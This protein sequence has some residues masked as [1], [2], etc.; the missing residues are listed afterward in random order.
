MALASR[1][2]IEI[3]TEA[4]EN[5]K[6][7]Y[8]AVSAVMLTSCPSGRLVES[9][10]QGGSLANLSRQ[11]D[12][13]N[14]LYQPG[15]TIHYAIRYISQSQKNNRSL[16]KIDSVIFCRVSATNEDAARL[17]ITDQTEQLLLQ[18]RG[19]LP[20]YLW[21]VVQDVQEFNRVWRPIDWDKAKVVEVRR[22]EELVALDSI[23]P[24][25]GIG[26]S[27]PDEKKSVKTQPKVYFVHQFLPHPGRLERLL[28]LILLNPGVMT[29][30]I[31]LAPAILTAREEQE[32]ID[33][34]ALSEGFTENS[35]PNM[36]R[37]QERRANMI[38]DGL[39]NQL[40]SLQ[41]A[42]FYMTIMLASSETI[43]STLVEA[44]GVAVS[45][46]VGEDKTPF[47][48]ASSLI[49]MGGYDLV[50]PQT[51]E[52]RLTARGNLSK[53]TQIPW[54]KTNAP[55]ELNRIRYMMDGHQAVCAFRFPED[56]REGL[57][58][59]T[60]HTL[61]HRPV[62]PEL[63]NRVAKL[64]VPQTLLLGTN[65]YLGITNEVLMPIADRLRHMYLVGQTG[66]GKSTLMKTML[67]SD[68]QAGRG[69]ALID[70]HGDLFDEIL[71]YIPPERI[72][73]VVIIDPADMEN[74]V[75]MNLLE[76]KGGDERYF[77]VREM[78]AIIRRILE[79]QYGL[80]EAQRIAGP[81]FYRHMQM[82][83]LLA[84]SDPDHTGTLLEFHEIYMT[85][86]YWK[87]WVPL[88]IDDKQLR[89][90][91]EYLAHNNYT[92]QAAGGECSMGE[93]LCS[94]FSDF[95]F[96][97]RLRLIFGQHNSTFDLTE[98]MDEGKILLINLA[99]GLL[100]ESNARFLGLV[101]MAKIQAE[102]MKRAKVPQSKRKPF[103]LYVDEFQSLAT[104]NFTVLLSEAR[105]FKL[106]IV[107]ANQFISQI[108][109]EKIIQA[110]FGNVGSLLSF[111]LGRDDA[112]TVEPQ[113][114]PFFDMT[115][116]INMPNWTVA[117]RTSVDGATLPPFTLQTTL[118]I[119]EPNPAIARQAREFS[120]KK[121][122]RTR[123]QVE[124]MIAESLKTVVSPKDE[125]LTS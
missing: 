43:P 120:R 71:G 88:K 60:T 2:H 27:Q 7:I 86:D 67:I 106:G 78:Q 82:N 36:Q 69:C 32:F 24:M 39:V 84:M 34:I 9:N 1:P 101:L 111:R 33:A 123:A 19:S 10:G 54:G 93:Y 14:S 61:R 68:M 87:R 6:V 63:V 114:L 102:A 79:D 91:L 51:K 100:G 12:L 62:P 3:F 85:K 56:T 22:R 119:G 28:R 90:W 35:M 4:G 49:Q 66:T 55:P 103:F 29:I 80:F 65:N 26:F 89:S 57:P 115:D 92:T 122:T 112:K 17:L 21:Q 45:A 59:I 99:K 73:D 95:I 108:K 124:E 40:L 18:L 23:R 8:H 110:L 13:I 117:A 31:I 97:P 70:P 38:R 94:K 83:M 107:L 58:G 75:G 25:R 74:P 44:A 125:G 109:D 52:E 53:L 50:T 116:L 46:S 105:K 96:D 37:I 15:S 98:I 11:I 76:A 64:D 30:T 81:I 47:L 121:Y 5:E 48:P 77:V 41:D 20:D 118:P 104:E 72:E 113:F 16:G 42:P